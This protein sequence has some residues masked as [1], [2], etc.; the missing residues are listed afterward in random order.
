MYFCN[1]FLCYKWVLWSCRMGIAR[2]LPMQQETGSHQRWYPST[3]LRWW[4]DLTW[5]ILFIKGKA[6]QENLKAV[7]VHLCNSNDLFNFHY[8][9]VFVIIVVVSYILL[10]IYIL[11]RRVVTSPKTL[12]C[13]IFSVFTLKILPLQS[14]TSTFPGD[15]FSG[16]AGYNTSC[17]EH[18]SGCPTCG[19]SD[20]GGRLWSCKVRRNLYPQLGWG[21]D[22]VLGAEGW[23]DRNDLL[24]G[25]TYSHLHVVKRSVG[26]HIN[27]EH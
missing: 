4:V 6:P 1:G 12:L 15:R 9:F 2:W 8:Y 11:H 27:M 24:R 16:Q 20:W 21:P 5:P 14:F 25:R 7:E 18:H 13:I 3:T 10:D 23:E 19:R 26:T 17:R 22:Q